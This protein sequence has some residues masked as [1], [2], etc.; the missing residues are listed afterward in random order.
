MAFGKEQ[1]AALRAAGRLQPGAWLLG[2]NWDESKWG[3]ELPAAGWVDGCTAQNPAFLIRMDSHMGLANSQAL[4]LAGVGA[5]TPDPAGGV[6]H[7]RAAGRGWAGGGGAGRAQ[8]CPFFLRLCSACAHRPGA[9]QGYAVAC[10]PSGGSLLGQPLAA[11][12]AAQSSVPAA[13]GT[14]RVPP[15]GCWPMQP[16]RW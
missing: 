14:P 4:S 10:L 16:R 6:V 11:L 15:R 7:R 12:E 5:A 9:G 13:T 3:G 2:G 1:C 8:L